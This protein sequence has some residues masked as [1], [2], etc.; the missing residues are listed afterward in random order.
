V[1]VFVP[2]LNGLNV[3]LEFLDAN[4]DV[5]ENVF[6]VKNS[7]PWTAADVKTML[8]AFITWF[9]TGAGGHS[10]KSSLSGDCAL[11]AV[12]GR[13]FT[14]VNG[15]VVVDQA[16]LPIAGTS[17]AHQIESGC[18]KSITAR[19]GLAGKSYRGRIF[20]CGIGSSNVPN[21]YSGEILVAYLTSMVTALNGL[22]PAVTSAIATCELVVC[23]RYG[24]TPPVG[25]HS[26]PRA[27]AVMTPIT[28]WGY[29]DLNVDFQRRRA[30]GHARHR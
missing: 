23:S 1:S 16:G 15:M 19:T 8:D 4:G 25:G 6:W 11:T 26:V 29:H 17:D 27:T 14:T 5:N 24:G 3:V 9:G 7:A 18:T 12:V 21:P 2:A 20:A 30:P 13:D 28:S 22:G 10:Y